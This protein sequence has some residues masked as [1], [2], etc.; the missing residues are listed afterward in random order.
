MTDGYT[1]DLN[2]PFA[3]T[4]C[5]DFFIPVRGSTSIGQATQ[6]Y[7]VP[8]D[9]Q[10]Y[11]YPYWQRGIA[12][13]TNNGGAAVAVSDDC[14]SWTD[15]TAYAAGIPAELQTKK[16]W[17]TYSPTKTNRITNMLAAGSNG[18]LA[19]N[20]HFDEAPASGAEIRVTYVTGAIPKTANNV[21]DCSMTI[22][23]NEGEL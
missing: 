11:Y 18:S 4:A 2:K 16:Y 13:F 7:T 8:L 17:R 10:L 5:E 3:P 9:Y 6:S 12:S 14:I 23:V 22:T 19:T 21:L 15:I 20:M 1:I